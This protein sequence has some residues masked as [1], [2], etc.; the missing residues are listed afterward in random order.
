MAPASPCF[1]PWAEHRLGP[2]TV[3]LCVN[4]EASLKTKITSPLI[5]R[6][7]KQGIFESKT[8][9]VND[10][11]VL[12]SAL[13]ASALRKK[14]ACWLFPALKS[15]IYK[16]SDGSDTTVNQHATGDVRRNSL[17][18]PSLRRRSPTSLSLLRGERTWKTAARP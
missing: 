13:P 9:Q 2:G 12:S 6:L 18:G 14:R 10:A 5:F 7:L 15:F 8:W 1:R 4:Q 3:H 11:L 17:L 16:Q